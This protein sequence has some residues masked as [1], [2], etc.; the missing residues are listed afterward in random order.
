VG[1]YL[2]VGLS[3]FL[4]LIFVLTDVFVMIAVLHDLRIRGDVHPALVRGGL[5]VVG[6]QPVVMALATTPAFLTFADLFR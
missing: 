1:S 4:L 5:A 3:G 6:V 2:G